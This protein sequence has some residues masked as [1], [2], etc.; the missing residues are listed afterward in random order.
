VLLVVHYKDFKSNQL[1]VLSR[2]M[3]WMAP[4]NPI[5]GWISIGALTLA[6]LFFFHKRSRHS[7]YRLPPR[8]PGTVMNMLENFRSD[9]TPDYLLKVIRSSQQKILSFP[10][11]PFQTC[12]VLAD[13]KVAR[14]ILDDPTSLKWYLGYSFFDKVA[15]GDNF[16]SSEGIRASHVRKHTNGAFRQSHVAAMSETVELVLD[17]WIERTFCDDNNS[18]MLDMSEE[19]QRLT[20]IVIGK[21]GFDYDLSGEE[22]E[23]A[24][25][26]L[27]LAYREFGQKSQKYPQRAIF[28]L[29]YPGVRR[30]RLASR[31]LIHLGRKM[32][33]H[34]R[35]QNRSNPTILKFIVNDPEYNNDDERVRDMV[36]YF[37]GGYDTTSYTI[38]WTLL[39]LAKNPE[40]Q[41]WLRTE[42]LQLPENER[43]NCPALKHTIR[44]SMRLH[45]TTAIG[46]L[47]VP[48]KDYILEKQNMV[49]PKGSVVFVATHC[50]HRD[51]DVYEKA[52]SFLPQRWLN[53]TEEMNRNWLGF[54]TGRR[55]CQGQALA[56]AELSVVLAKLCSDFE[57]TVVQEGHV[58]YYVTRKS[59][60]AVLKATRVTS[61]H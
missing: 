53:P 48:A 8:A 44:E 52:D 57:W 46:A 56:Q 61:N 33:A 16:F 34:Y 14:R 3:E 17:D 40:A 10:I 19:M 47:R 25:L 37:A 18:R 28:G 9:T 41:T 54:G 36:G 30:A 60:G 12:I 20:L 51:Q 15:S 49:I 59:V 6:F 7:N 45:I 2:R 42:L 5:Y 55:S 43:R 24:L 1:V 39:E 32:L 29:L 23:M 11:L 26:S 50:I 38:S 31:D 4:L 21:I 35:A 27:K 58:E 22:M 13:A